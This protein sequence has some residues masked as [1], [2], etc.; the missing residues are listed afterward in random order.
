MDRNLE[1]KSFSE[2][3]PQSAKASTSHG[4]YSFFLNLDEQAPYM[5]NTAYSARMSPYRTS[6]SQLYTERQAYTDRITPIDLNYE[7]NLDDLRRQISYLRRQIDENNTAYIQDLSTQKQ[8]YEKQ[9]DFIQREKELECINLKQRLNEVENL[10]EKERKIG[11]EYRVQHF[12]LLSLNSNLQERIK[13]LGLEIEQL[14]EDKEALKKEIEDLKIE[15]NDLIGNHHKKVGEIQEDFNRS[16]REYR[17]VYQKL[18]SV[19]EEQSQQVKSLERVIKE[20]KANYER[21]ISNLEEMLNST[22]RLLELREKDVKDLLWNEEQYKAKIDTLANESSYSRYE[23]DQIH[24]Q[25]LSLKQEVANLK[26][27]QLR[28]AKII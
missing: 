11:E 16:E 2:K 25:N 24:K 1:Q 13:T 9:I 18:E 4:R 5:P 12:G 6:T 10:A 3:R 14:S 20:N 28:K 26:K 17:E 23:F 8:E 27:Q 21:D 15:K 19:I 7:K 22:R